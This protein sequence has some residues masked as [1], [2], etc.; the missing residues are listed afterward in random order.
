MFK[1]NA[2]IRFA[3]IY[4]PFMTPKG[5][6]R[7]GVVFVPCSDTDRDELDLQLGRSFYR[8]NH[9]ERRYMARS[10]FAPTVTF[11]GLR[12]VVKDLFEV[13]DLRNVSRDALFRGVNAS[14]WL[15]VKNVEW[16][17]HTMT[18]LNVH[19]VVVDADDLQIPERV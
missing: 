1:V 3:D 6:P 7:F 17:N 15:S 12:S 19:E 13:A 4:K 14:L 5:T 18:F 8:E 10:N 2:I 16:Q 9:G 11:R